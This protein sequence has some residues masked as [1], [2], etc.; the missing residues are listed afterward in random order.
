MRSPVSGALGDWGKAPKK[1]KKKNNYNRIRMIAF[2]FILRG[3]VC[4]GFGRGSKELGIPTANLPESEVEK[5]C[6]QVQTGVYYGWAM[7]HQKIYKM[8]MSIGWNP[9][10]KNTKKTAEV[11]IMHNFDHDFYGEILSVMVVGYIRDERN[12]SSLDELIL[13][14][15]NDISIADREL[16]KEVNVK[17]KHDFANQ[18]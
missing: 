14:I 18:P 13:E 2:P 9:Y 8:V 5:I 6:Q 3:K 17:L 1:K 16:D 15:K 4:K 10:Y 11:H 7:L 12:F